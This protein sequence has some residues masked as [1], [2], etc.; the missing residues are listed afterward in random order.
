MSTHEPATP[1][2]IQVLR[3]VASEEELAAL[4]AVLGEAYTAEETSAV[5]AQRRVSV[6][7][8]GQRGVRAPLRR[9]IPWGRFSG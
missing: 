2:E 6:W 7:E 9:D 5:A 1:V 3:G 8:R 4:L